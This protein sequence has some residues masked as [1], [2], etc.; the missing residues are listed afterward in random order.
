MDTRT[1]NAMGQSARDI[2]KAGREAAE[3]LAQTGRNVGERLSSA[4]QNTRD[5]IQE[6][7]RAGVEVTDKTVREHPYSSIGVAFCAG[8]L[9][10]VLLTRG[11]RD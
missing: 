2:S 5:V 10:G 11:G 1:E 4:W 9:L 3:D 8:L 6:K 7:T